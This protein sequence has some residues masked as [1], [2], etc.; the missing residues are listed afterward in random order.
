MDESKS[1]IEIKETAKGVPCICLKLYQGITLEEL[2]ELKVMAL[3]A[4][5]ELRAELNP[6]KF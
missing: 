1:S 5:K 4:H 2:D 3:K 6:Y